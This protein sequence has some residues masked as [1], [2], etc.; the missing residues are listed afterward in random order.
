M[1]RNFGNKWEREFIQ[2]YDSRWRRSKIDSFNYQLLEEKTIF[3]L[4]CFMSNYPKLGFLAILLV[5][6][7]QTCILSLEEKTFPSRNLQIG[8]YSSITS[9]W[10]S[11]L[12]NWR[13]IM[14]EIL[15]ISRT[16]I[17]KSS[18][19]N[20]WSKVVKII[21]KSNLFKA[22]YSNSSYLPFITTIFSIPKP[23]SK[24]AAVSWRQRFVGIFLSAVN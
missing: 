15:S 3:R 10:L 23:I 18:H 1:S 13:T 8:D 17:T 7:Q 6:S 22:L 2:S 19:R 14:M 5:P 9:F 21:C 16:K 24:G 20:V 4:S 12:T 11:F